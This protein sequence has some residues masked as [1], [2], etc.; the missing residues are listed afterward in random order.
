MNFLILVWFAIL[1]GN[2]IFVFIGRDYCPNYL[3]MVYAFM[4]YWITMITLLSVKSWIV[5]IKSGKEESED[6]KQLKESIDKLNNIVK[7]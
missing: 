1:V 2:I 3:D 6:V 5:L 4:P 7:K